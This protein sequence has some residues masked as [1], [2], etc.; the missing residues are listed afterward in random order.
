MNYLQFVETKA[1]EY[2]NNCRNDWRY[3]LERKFNK[4][5]VQTCICMQSSAFGIDTSILNTKSIRCCNRCQLCSRCQCRWIS[6]SQY[7]IHS[8]YGDYENW[9]EVYIAKVIPSTWYD[10]KKA[11]YN[12]AWDDFQKPDVQFMTEDNAVEKFN[13]VLHKYPNVR[14]WITLE[15]LQIAFNLRW[16]KM[17]KLISR[18]MEQ[19]QQYF[20]VNGVYSAL[21]I[22]DAYLEHTADYTTRYDVT[23]ADE[24]GKYCQPLYLSHCDDQSA[25]MNNDHNLEEWM[26]K[27]ASKKLMKLLARAM[28][29][30]TRQWLVEECESF[31]WDEQTNI[32]GV[33]A[34]VNRDTNEKNIL[35]SRK[36]ISWHTKYS[37]MYCKKC[38]YETIP[39]VVP[40]N[41]Y[42]ELLNRARMIRR[43][44][45]RGVLWCS[46]KILSYLY[47]QRRYRPN[48]IKYL[49]AMQN[50]NQLK[51]IHY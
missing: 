17:I 49:E 21:S 2:A 20:T 46:I 32:I 50:F 13:Y 47:L 43:N 35:I 37:S 29:S 36:N 18:L 28:A 14:A 11:R 19:R 42:E 25:T 27:D 45:F 26:K 24:Y 23:I 5:D 4:N 7:D 39:A 40:K 51:E 6:T 8:S 22:E 16:K 9:K 33:K 30:S 31:H 15:H 1:K 38:N 48:G 3:S 12:F 41:S 44:K 34:H 10:R